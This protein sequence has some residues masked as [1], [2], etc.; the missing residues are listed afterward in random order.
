MRIGVIRIDD[1]ERGFASQ[2]A[3]PGVD[4]AT[5]VGDIAP[6][7]ATQRVQGAPGTPLLKGK[8]SCTLSSKPVASN[9]AWRP[10]KS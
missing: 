6:Q 3:S 8:Q 10:K 5:G 1:R 2:M 7:T 4:F 9:I